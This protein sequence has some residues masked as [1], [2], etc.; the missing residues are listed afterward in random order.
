MPTRSGDITAH[1]RGFFTEYCTA[2]IRQDGA[3]IA[4][5]FAELVHTTSDTGKDVRVH[6]STGD[7]VRKTIDHLL[8]LYRAIDFGTAEAIGLATDPLSSRLVQVRIRWA[9]RNK[10]GA[11]LY[12][13]DAM[14]TLARH[15]DIFRITA[16]AH[17]EMSHYRRCVAALA[18]MAPKK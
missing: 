11:L 5:H 2:F 17:N 6:V 8:G 12:E 1:V 10:S 7:E 3:A 15:A 4:K 14:Y 9:L 18:E 16:V 13:F